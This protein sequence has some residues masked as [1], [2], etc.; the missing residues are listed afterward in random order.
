MRVHFEKILK[1]PKKNWSLLHIKDWNFKSMCPSHNLDRP[2]TFTT[3]N[4][5]NAEFGYIETN[6][7]T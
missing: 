5:Y 4:S 2:Q 7:K 1:Q 3:I 6:S